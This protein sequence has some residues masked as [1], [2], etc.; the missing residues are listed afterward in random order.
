VIV[1]G[2]DVN[3]LGDDINE[4]RNTAEILHQTRKEIGLEGNK[5][6]TKYRNVI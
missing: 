6:K 5:H 2:D 3:L 1:D 4:M